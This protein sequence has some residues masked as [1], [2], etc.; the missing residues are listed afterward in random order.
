MYLRFGAAIAALGAAATAIVVT[1]TLVRSVPGPTNPTSSAPA[2]APSS[3]GAPLQPGNAA[4]GRNATPD[5]PGVPAP[6]EDAVVLAQEAGLR[7]LA[8][9]VKPGLVR[10][11]VLGTAGGGE[12]K[13]NVSLQFGAG[14]PRRT[15]PCGAG[16]YQLDV[17]GTPDSPVTV[18]IGGDPY[19]FDLP[20]L[21]ARDATAIVR[22]ATDT[23]NALRTLV[24]HE[25][26]ASSPANVLHTVYR[27]VAPHSLAYT[28]AGRSAAVIVGGTRWDRV[29]PTAQWRRSVQ[30]PPVRQPQPF[31]E[32]A[33]D[34]RVLGTER[35]GTH[36][37]WRV[38]FFDPTTPAWFEA[39]I[40]RKT[41]RTLELDMVAAS[42]FMHH[43]Y[44][45][46]DAPLTLAPPT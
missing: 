39:S 18:R 34:A 45:P 19:R 42:H 20:R 43:V 31:W 25:R 9:A 12:A 3:G 4:P 26:L 37:V 40:D 5:D 15:E 32:E 27:A 13:L 23:W 29:S 30:N 2:A 28:I 22:R 11:S 33:T 16:C 36:R 1:V 6:P 38:S 24:W 10:V 8:L 17:H 14:S 46:F 44:G 7:A 41:G 35:L 21:P